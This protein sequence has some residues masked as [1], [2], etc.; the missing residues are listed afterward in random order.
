MSSPQLQ[1][2][3]GV[4]SSASSAAI[5]PMWW[6]GS[7]NA[8]ESGMHQLAPYV[9]KMKSAMA[10][11]LILAYSGEGDTVL[12]P[13]C[14]S[15]VVPFEA[16]LLGREAIGND[17]NPYAHVLTMAK[18]TAPQGL[19]DALSRASDYVQ[20]AQATADGLCLDAVPK[21]V[22][23][24]FHPQTLRETV[25]VFGLLRQRGEYFF[26]A[27]ILGILHHVRPGFLSYPASHLVPYLRTK[28]YPPEKFPQMYAY[29]DLKSR[30]LAKVRRAYRR[31][32]PPDTR[33]HWRVLQENAMHLSIP[34]GSVDAIVSSPPYF[35]ALDYGRDNRLRLWFLGVE[36]YKTVE[37]ELTSN[38]RVYV[39]Q[40]TRAVE[41][42]H[43][44][45]RI[46]GAAVLVLG[47]YHRN[48]RRAHSADT[49]AGIARRHLADRLVVDEI[50]DDEVPDQRRSRRRTRTTLQE[51][52]L[53]LRKM[54]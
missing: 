50:F 20:E 43:R 49:I 14:G 3:L 4:P 51:R 10:R 39:P 25:A 7:F 35:G 40:M 31:Y 30:F 11:A 24:F 18:L 17:L 45:L 26:Q 32:S 53:V 5:D 8:R 29:R 41:E 2:P 33:L 37:A 36:D 16:L 6:H 23:E 38:D 46:G 22:R 54:E 13:F 27:C 1:L 19:R 42:M 15:G 34:G 21:W 9:G 28:L 48:G 47:D 12:D 44:V 52:V